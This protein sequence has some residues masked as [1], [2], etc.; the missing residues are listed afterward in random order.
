MG[1]KGIKN[2]RKKSGLK[3]REVAAATD[4]C[5]RAVQKWEEGRV[6]P[7]EGHLLK[8]QELFGTTMDELIKGECDENV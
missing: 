8:L 2:L 7:R 1:L 6:I 3:L 4:V 5:L